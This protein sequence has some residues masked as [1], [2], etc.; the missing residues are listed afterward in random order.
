MHQIAEICQYDLSEAERQ[1]ILQAEA[2]KEKDKVI[3]RLQQD[4]AIARGEAIKREP[5]DDDPYGR[6]IQ[7]IRLPPKVSKKAVPLQQ[8][9]LV[10]GEMSDN[11]Y[12]DNP[13]VTSVAEEV[14]V[15]LRLDELY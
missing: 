15:Y 12:F 7:K 4:L 10:Q 1:P 9:Y 5:Q 6:S 8:K 3:A 13:G 14:N 11:A 2:L